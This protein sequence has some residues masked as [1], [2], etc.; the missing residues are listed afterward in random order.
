M[1][2]TIK[3]YAMLSEYLPAHAVK[4]EAHLQLN[5]N[6]CVSEVISQ[7]NM[8]RNMVHLVLLNGVYV[9]PEQ[10]AVTQLS[11]SDVLAIWPPVAGG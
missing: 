2:I 10:L 3:L 1:H 9:E 6:S 4:N 8:P 11:E 7:L 5:E